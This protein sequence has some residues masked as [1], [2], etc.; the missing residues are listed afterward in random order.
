MAMNSVLLSTMLR[1]FM[2]S[3]HKL[4]LLPG[5][6]NSES[7]DCN[8]GT[9]LWLE[10]VDICVVCGFGLLVFNGLKADEAIDSNV[11][12]KSWIGA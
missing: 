5:L 10:T 7:V 2:F 8:L 6:G 9:Q 11:I 1:Q 4:F 12:F 3:M